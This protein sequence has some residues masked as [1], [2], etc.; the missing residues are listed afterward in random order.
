MNR[1]AY[2]TFLAGLV[3]GGAGAWL[4]YPKA[5]DLAV[6]RDEKIRTF[7]DQDVRRYADAHTVDEKFRAANG[8]YARAVELFVAELGLP[9][10]GLPP[11]ADL[12]TPKDVGVEGAA[13]VDEGDPA[14]GR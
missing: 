4:L 3:I 1:A 10:T 9:V 7:V 2:G 8:M 12:V 14:A 11:Q 13:P 6:L 5:P